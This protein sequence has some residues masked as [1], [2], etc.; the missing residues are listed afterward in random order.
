MTSTLRHFIAI[1]SVA[2]SFAPAT[3]QIIDSTWLAGNYTKQEVM[4]PMRD[5]VKLFTAI[6]S[7]KSVN[8]KHPLLIM[9]TP[10]SVGPYGTSMLSPRLY[11]THWREYV[12]RG[13]II[14]MQDVRGRYMSEG[15]FMDVRPFN[16][17]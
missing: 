5:G 12:K 1:W 4:I 16:K 17:S 15:E 8:E 9:R 14:V 11:A 13:Y 3:A 10:Y 6:Y 7:P 2:L